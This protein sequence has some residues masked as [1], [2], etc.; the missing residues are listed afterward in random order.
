MTFAR[1]T[2]ISRC[3]IELEITHFTCLE[4]ISDIGRKESLASLI[5]ERRITSLYHTLSGK[6]I[7]PF[8][9]ARD[10]IEEGRSHLTEVSAAHADAS[11]ILLVVK[12]R[13]FLPRGIAECT[14]CLLGIIIA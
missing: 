14:D 9:F 11:N 3:C 4:N 2:E 5:E 8:S 7:F 6:D 13:I 12:L 10:I 1:T